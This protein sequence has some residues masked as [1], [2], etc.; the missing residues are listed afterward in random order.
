[1]RNPDIDYCG[2][3]NLLRQLVAAAHCSKKEAQNIAS[4]IAVQY[5]ANIIIVP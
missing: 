5:G 2:V 1:M 3:V 4:R